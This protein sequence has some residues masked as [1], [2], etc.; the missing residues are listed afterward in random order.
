MSRTT[1]PTVSLPDPLDDF[2]RERVAPGRF[3]SAADLI[4]TAVEGLERRD[5]VGCPQAEA[6]QLEDGASVLRRIPQRRTTR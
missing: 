6:G 3:A 5:G 1:P 2:V 4:R